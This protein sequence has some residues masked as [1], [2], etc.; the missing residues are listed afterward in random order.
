[1]GLNFKKLDAIR[2]IIS[3]SEE[4]K[5]LGQKLTQTDKNGES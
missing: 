1:M 4:K 5:L 3:I 2:I